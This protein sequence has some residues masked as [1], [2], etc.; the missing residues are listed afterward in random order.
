MGKSDSKLSL[1]WGESSWL[2]ISVVVTSDHCDLF[3]LRGNSSCSD[4][5]CSAGLSERFSLKK[6][7]PVLVECKP[8]YLKPRCFEYPL[9]PPWELVV[10]LI[11]F[12]A[13]IWLRCVCSLSPKSIFVMGTRDAHSVAYSLFRLG[14]MASR[15]RCD[16]SNKIWPKSP[17]ASVCNLINCSMSGDL[18]SLPA[19][20]KSS[21][22]FVQMYPTLVVVDWSVD[23][24]RS[25]PCVWQSSRSHI[26]GLT[27]GGI[28]LSRLAGR[29]YF[30]VFSFNCLSL[31][32]LGQQF[33]MIFASF[34]EIFASVFS[35][36]F[37]DWTISSSKVSSSSSPSWSFWSLF[38]SKSWS[39]SDYAE[40]LSESLLVF[41]SRLAE[42]AGLGVGFSPNPHSDSLKG[43]HRFVH[44]CEQS[45]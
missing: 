15:Q 28:K 11:L 43:F 39:T 14:L 25:R 21:V 24:L 36:S 31:S 20:N 29:T 35:V 7:L 19:C 37:F 33:S 18:F 4:R 16:I 1:T 40:L 6:F 38:D 41:R 42:S 45:L 34:S 27:L 9:F 22:A 30:S 13:R 23:S 8:R 26:W 3:S 2:I 10:L 32:L 44:W 5:G 17:R 12:K